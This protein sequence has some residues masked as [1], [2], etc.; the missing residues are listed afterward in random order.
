MRKLW[1]IYA[2]N[3]THKI[4]PIWS[5]DATGNPVLLEDKY[6]ITGLRKIGDVI[7]SNSYHI[8]WIRPSH[9]LGTSLGLRGV[10]RKVLEVPKSPWIK[11][12]SIGGPRMIVPT[13]IRRG[14]T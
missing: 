5:S 9:D 6:L 14:K 7:E 10:P 4:R 12:A 13:H 3:S 1:V 11:G 8:R 2:D